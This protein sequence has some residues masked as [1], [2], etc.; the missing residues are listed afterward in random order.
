MNLLSLLTGELRVF[1]QRGDP[2]NIRKSKVLEAFHALQRVHPLLARY[3]MPKLTYSLINYHISENKHVGIDKGWVNNILFGKYDVNPQA[4]DVEF[5]DLIIGKDGVGKM[6]RYS[7]PSL[8]ALVFPHL[9]T[10]CTGNYSMVL[11]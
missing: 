7:H 10:T 6:I 4:S 5:K 3:N 11:L 2:S 1:Y 8:L 9:Y